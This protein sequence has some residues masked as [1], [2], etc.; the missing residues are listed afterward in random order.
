MP[1]ADRP[2]TNRPLCPLCGTEIA[3]L[4]MRIQSRPL[5]QLALVPAG[6]V[7]LLK[8][9]PHLGSARLSANFVAIATRR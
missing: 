1:N 4:A 2:D 5:R 6:L 7:G 8:M 9:L 3:G